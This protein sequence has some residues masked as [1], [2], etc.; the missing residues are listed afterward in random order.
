MAVPNWL[1]LASTRVLWLQGG[2]GT[3]WAVFVFFSRTWAL[4]SELGTPQAQ[5]GSS[6]IGQPYTRLAFRDVPG[7]ARQPRNTVSLETRGLLSVH[8]VCARRRALAAF[9]LADD[10]LKNSPNSGGNHSSLG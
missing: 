3:E 8:L 1:S 7:L 6:T 10:N 5:E 9:F 2:L 4:V